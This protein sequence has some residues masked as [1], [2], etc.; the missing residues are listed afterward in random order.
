[1][2]SLPLKTAKRLF[3]KPLRAFGGL[4]RP[5]A[6]SAALTGSQALLALAW[7]IWMITCRNQERIPLPI[8]LTSK[9]TVIGLEHETV[10]QVGTTWKTTIQQFI[11]TKTYRLQGHHLHHKG[12]LQGRRWIC[13]LVQMV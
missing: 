1:M 2:R 12:L 7:T 4:L 5:V 6:V 13:G 9:L 11:S 3:T 10:Q 8:I